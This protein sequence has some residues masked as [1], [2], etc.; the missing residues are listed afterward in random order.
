[1][2]IN[3]FFFYAFTPGVFCPGAFFVGVNSS[4]NPNC[5]NCRLAQLSENRGGLIGG[6]GLPL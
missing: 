5:P 1:L 3:G 6:K 4:D 2:K